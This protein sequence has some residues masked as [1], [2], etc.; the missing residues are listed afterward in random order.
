MGEKRGTE[1]GSWGVVLPDVHTL[2]AL[3]LSQLHCVDIG[4]YYVTPTA[5][6]PVKSNICSVRGP[7]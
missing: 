2:D 3:Y 7:S 1:P 4:K 6:P 5:G